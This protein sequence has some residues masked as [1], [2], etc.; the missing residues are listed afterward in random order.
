MIKTAMNHRGIPEKRRS[1][2]KRHDSV[3]EIF[4]ESGHLITGIGRLVDVSATGACFSTTRILEVNHPFRVRL[5]LLMEGPLEMSAHIV[6]SR[7]KNNTILYG[8]AFD[9]LH[10]TNRLSSK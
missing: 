10:K 6:W 1:P 2:R 8:I 4:D 5:R 3:M 9:P 7:K